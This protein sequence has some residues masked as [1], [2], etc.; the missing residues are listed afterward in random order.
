MSNSD[1]PLPDDVAL[2]H[3]II[4]QQA[5]TIRE[6]RR[7]IEQ[8]EH[9]AEQ[10][11]RRQ[12]G[13]RRES[14]DPDQ[15]RLFAD[16]EAEGDPGGPPEPQDAPPE[17]RRWRRRGRQRLPEHLLCERIE[18]ELT[19]E[20]LSCPDCGCVR[21]KIGEEVSEQLEYI[22]ASMRVLQHVRFRYACRGCQE[23]V[24]IAA[25]PPQPIDKGL[26]GPGLLA[27]TITSKY[28]DHLPLYRL[29]DIFARHGVELS[30]ATLCGWMASCA[31]LL[32]PLYDLMVKRVLLS[33]AIHT[34][35]T[36]VPV[37]DPTLPKT[38]TGRFWVYV[39]DARHPYVVYDYTPRRTRDGPERFPKGYR[40][41]LQADA[42]SGYDGL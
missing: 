4:R 40:G 5:D 31:E 2:C 25:K 10:L 16:E 17:R 8:L 41:Y 23:H 33:A 9:Q 30:R 11:L 18:Y 29:E 1:V 38:R 42:F 15:L 12:Y 34:H 26:P 27:Q 13:P 19:A 32:T 37:L 36:R 21:V 35:D 14:V 6:S 28:G 24:A 39:G 3:E 22:P 20:E 7:R